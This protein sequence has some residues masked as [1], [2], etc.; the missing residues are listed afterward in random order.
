MYRIR[1]W[2]GGDEWTGWGEELSREGWLKL[3]SIR[4]RD[5]C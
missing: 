5:A 3:K 4:W 2:T 1:V